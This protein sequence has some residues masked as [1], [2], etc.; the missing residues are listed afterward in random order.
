MSNYIV[1]IDIGSSKIYAAV[2]KL[3]EN[4]EL[5]MVGIDSV[6]CKGVRKG[7]IIDIN[8]TANSIKKCIDN[9]EDMLNIEIK[10]VY[11]SIPSGLCEFVDSKGVV[12]ITSDNREI[13][14]DDIFRVEESAKLISLDSK[15]KIVEVIPENYVIDGKYNVKNAIGMTGTRLEISAKVVFAETDLINKIINSV[16]MTGKKVDGIV[17]ASQAVLRT[18]LDNKEYNNAIALVD[19]GSQTIDISIYK[20]YIL[21]YTASIPLGGNNIT[22]DISICLNMKYDEAE[23][24][25][26]KYGSLIGKSNSIQGTVKNRLHDGSI[27]EFDRN[28][29]AEII[30]AR[31]EELL[32]FISVHLKNSGYFNEIDKVILFGGGMS[33]FGGIENFASDILNKPVEVSVSRCVCEESPL[34]VTCVG[35]VKYVAET[36]LNENISCTENEND[37]GNKYC[38]SENIRYEKRKFLKTV[39]DYLVDFFNI[40]R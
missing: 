37:I 5:Q 36:L 22:N 1:G 6:K 13:N 11:V 3:D 9:I 24:I 12:A 34:Y 40:R 19:I 26:V 15:K 7:I 4:R 39:K 31:A 28:M 8:D 17:V 10:G 35:I 16:N 38:D 33:L 20:N 18:I 23:G 30:E 14:Y 21:C 27:I 25:K 2:G 32:K 29:L